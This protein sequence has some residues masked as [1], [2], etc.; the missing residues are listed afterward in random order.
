MIK[1]KVDQIK[2]EGE[3]LLVEPALLDVG[4][5][6]TPFTYQTGSVVLFIKLNSMTKTGVINTEWDVAQLFNSRNAHLV[7]FEFGS[8]D[9]ER[10]SLITDGFHY[11]A[12][13][14]NYA[15]QLEYAVKAVIELASHTSLQNHQMNVS[16]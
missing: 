1:A 3:G 10:V 2:Q 14:S 7:T 5:L 13:S 15:Q 4:D 11:N 12:N 6:L 16:S 9:C 8:S